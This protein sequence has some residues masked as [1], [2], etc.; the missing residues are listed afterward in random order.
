MFFLK[1]HVRVKSTAS[2]AAVR[3]Q[4][5]C[6]WCYVFGSQTRH[7]HY[8]LTS[9]SSSQQQRNSATSAT[10][11]LQRS[12]CV[13]GSAHCLCWSSADNVANLFLYCDPKLLLWRDM[14]RCVMRGGH[15]CV[16]C[17]A[18]RPRATGGQRCVTPGRW[19]WW[20]A[21]ETHMQG[22]AKVAPAGFSLRS[23][24]SKRPLPVVF[25]LIS[26]TSCGIGSTHSYLFILDVSSRTDWF[27]SR[28]FMQFGINFCC[29][30]ST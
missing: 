15:V 29:N 22:L 6:E 4:P 21:G 20:Q 19:L 25:S 3:Q 1:N 10:W 13:H 18:L 27:S 8:T 7:Y 26:L 2:G 12:H 5:E 23:H 9:L 11:P 24:S 30:A 17:L 14:A 16:V 28:G